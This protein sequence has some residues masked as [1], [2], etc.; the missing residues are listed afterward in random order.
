[1]TGKKHSR[2]S[3]SSSSRWLNCPGSVNLSDGIEPEQIHPSAIEGTVA[4]GIAEKLIISRLGGDRYDLM[5]ME[6]AVISN[7]TVTKEMLNAAE[8]M[9]DVVESSCENGDE[10]F[11]EE[12][13]SLAYIHKEM[14]GTSD[15]FI[16]HK[17]ESITVIDFKYG[18]WPVDPKNNSQL[19]YYFLGARNE[20]RCPGGTLKIVQPR[21]RD[22]NVIKS[23]A[24]DNDTYIKWENI[25]REKSKQVDLGTPLVKG[26]WCMFCPAKKVCRLHVK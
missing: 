4:H 5:A 16:K 20:T 17:D 23:W 22:G 8:I 1:M 14:F 15:V 25:F 19:I 26:E 18:T 12:R 6:N 3:A 21:S 10:V 13:I 7:V 9:S 11:I 24:I 2:L